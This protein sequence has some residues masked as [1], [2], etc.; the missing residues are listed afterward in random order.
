MS[1]NYNWE[2]TFIDGTPSGTNNYWGQRP[3]VHVSFRG[4]WI[5]YVYSIHSW[6]SSLLFHG[7]YCCFINRN[8]ICIKVKKSNAAPSPTCSLPNGMYICRYKVTVKACFGFVICHIHLNCRCLF[9]FLFSSDICVLVF[10][11]VRQEFPVML[12]WTT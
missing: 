2:G 8:Y 4:N 5:S 1:K 7:G 3:T 12:L 9:Y 6:V 10:K 11:S